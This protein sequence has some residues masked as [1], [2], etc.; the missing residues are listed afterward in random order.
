ML[1]IMS[2]YTPSEHLCLVDRQWVESFVRE[3]R[4][5]VTDRMVWMAR[6]DPSVVEDDDE[7][8]RT[9]NNIVEDVSLDLVYDAGLY[10][11]NH[12]EAELLLSAFS[13]ND[14][15]ELGAIVILEDY[16]DV[17]AGEHK[18]YRE[19]V[20]NLARDPH[21][22][23]FYGDSTPL[24]PKGVDTKAVIITRHQGLVEFLRVHYPEL[25]QAKVIAHASVDDVLNKN[26]WGV[27]PLHLASLAETVTTVNLNLPPELRGVELT[28]EDIEKYFEGVETFV[29]ASRG[30]R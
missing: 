25:A 18:C 3:F 24:P 9:L 2:Q 5:E 16:A 14:D 8:I 28:L 20:E 7:Y 1:A 13:C 27:L 15:A 10:C 21:I 26:V 30:R 6:I 11:A 12:N 4:S 22:K 19:F 17:A 23:T 29:V